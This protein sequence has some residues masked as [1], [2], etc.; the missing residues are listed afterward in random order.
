[1]PGKEITP[2]QKRAVAKYN[3]KAYDRI[4]MKVKKGEKAAIIAH[5]KTMGETLNGFLN[6]AVKQTIERDNKEPSEKGV[7]K[8]R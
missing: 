8:C 5:S 2:A 3:A 7:T 6:R 1:M 4:E